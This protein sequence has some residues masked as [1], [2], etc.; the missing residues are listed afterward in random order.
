VSSP[1]A[2]DPDIQRFDGGCTVNWRK[3]ASAGG[4]VESCDGGLR[5]AVDVK[6]NPSVAQRTYDS[7]ADI[8]GVHLQADTRAMIAHELGHVYYIHYGLSSGT[9]ADWAINFENAAR[10]PGPQRP[11]GTE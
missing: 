3:E 5:D 8:W 11:F 6:V 7:F 9:S 10:S 2:S 4:I 1:S